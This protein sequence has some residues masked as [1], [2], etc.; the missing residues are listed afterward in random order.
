M[1]KE[2]GKFV[3]K[4]SPFEEE[5]SSEYNLTKEFKR[6]NKRKK[7]VVELRKLRQ[8]RREEDNYSF[9]EKKYFK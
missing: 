1:E 5:Y 3:P 9:A 2:V 7:E 6:N 4:F 8:H